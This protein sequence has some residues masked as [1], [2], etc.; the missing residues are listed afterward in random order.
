MTAALQQAKPN[1]GQGGFGGHEHHRGAGGKNLD[2]AATAI[3]VTQDQ[4]R[5]ALESGQS[6]ADVAKSN[7]KDPQVVIDAL[8]AAAKTHLTAEVTAGRIT[9]AQADSRWPRRP[10]ASPTRS[11]TSGRL[12][13]RRR[14]APR[15]LPPRPP[16]PQP[17]CCVYGMALSAWSVDAARSSGALATRV[18]DFG[19]VWSGSQG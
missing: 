10:P 9:Q 7:G 5:Q 6:I 13:P 19:D 18:T 11:T 15:L 2:T 8:V 16:E 12:G 1:A 14:R 17:P 3:G 4:L